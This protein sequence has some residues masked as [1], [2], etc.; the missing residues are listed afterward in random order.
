MKI[1][2]NGHIFFEF[3]KSYFFLVAGLL[4]LFFRLPLDDEK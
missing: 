1:K 2:F 4:K 3:Q